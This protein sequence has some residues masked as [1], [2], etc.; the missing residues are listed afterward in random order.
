MAGKIETITV[1]IMEQN[2]IKM[3]ELI[4]ISEGILLK[5]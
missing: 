3:I 4:F 1:I 5:K 2:E